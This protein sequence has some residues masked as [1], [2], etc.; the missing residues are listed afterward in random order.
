[1]S[2]E[3]IFRACMLPL[4]VPQFGEG[5]SVFICPLFFGVGKWICFKTAKK[6]F[7][8]T[9]ILPVFSRFK[10]LKCCLLSSKKVRKLEVTA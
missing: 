2:E 9:F 3:F 7:T 8:C 5:W 1:M 6:A 4:L 10:I